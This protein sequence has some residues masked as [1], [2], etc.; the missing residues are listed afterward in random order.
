M[1]RHEIDTWPITTAGLSSRPAT[2]LTRAGVATVGELRA[3]TDARLLE[4]PAFGVG[5]LRD[6]HW[7]FGWTQRLEDG[8][9]ALPDL[10]AWL[11]E[12]LTPLQRAVIEQ[13]FGLTDPLFRPWLKRDSLRIIGRQLRGGI[14]RERVRQIEEEGLARLRSRLARAACSSKLLG[15]YQRWGA[16]TLFG[17]LDQNFLAVPGGVA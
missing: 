6:V 14:T 11:A 8:Q 12:F 15:G 1:T 4:L 13:R 16:E 2:C 7:F 10:Q 9:A 17:A 3:W 5:S